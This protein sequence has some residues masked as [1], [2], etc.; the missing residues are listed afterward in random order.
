MQRMNHQQAIRTGILTREHGKTF[1]ADS[2]GTSRF[3]GEKIW[4][5]YLTHWLGLKVNA[6]L[7]AQRDYE[8][9]RNIAILWPWKEPPARD[10][11]EIYYNERLVKYP[12]SLFGHLA[13]NI[14]GAIYNYS[15]LMN[16]NEIISE[17][18][19]FYRPALGEFAPHPATSVFNVQDKSR[20]YYDRFGR[21]FMR[22]IHVL[23]I[24][25][26]DNELLKSYCDRMLQEILDTPDPQRP[27]KYRDFNIV[28]RS[29]V[30]IIRDGFH[31]AGYTDVSGRFPRDFFINA[32]Y[33]FIKL[34]GRGGIRAGLYR[35]PQLK[36]PEA[37]YSALTIMMNPFSRLLLR[38]LPYY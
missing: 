15:H 12:F 9:G 22:T 23:R 17:E 21:N 6:R 28:T 13:I 19:Y 32:A 38:K 7:L 36:V 27:E 8:T 25:G 30:T 16:E 26:L 11:V 24:E 35:M 5:G 29:C 33:N 3:E 14:D 31:H 2:T 10:Y 34:N 4:D 37:P 1:I 20:P 18:E